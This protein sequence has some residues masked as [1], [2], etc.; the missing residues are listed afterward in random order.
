MGEGVRNVGIKEG[1]EKSTGIV[2][3][4]E[5]IDGGGQQQKTEQIAGEVESREQGDTG[6]KH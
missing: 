1:V 2:Q 4:N 3:Q 5:Q 6:R